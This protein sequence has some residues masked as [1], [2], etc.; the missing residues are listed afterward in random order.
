[1]PN[2]FHYLALGSN[3]RSQYYVPAMIDQWARV[4][5]RVYLGP[6]FSTDPVGVVIDAGWPEPNDIESKFVNACFAIS[7]P[8]QWVDEQWCKG[9]AKLLEAAL[10]R[11]LDL[12]N[13]RQVSRTIDVDYLFSDAADVAGY[14]RQQESYSCLGLEHLLQHTQP[15]LRPATLHQP[16]SDCARAQHISK[17]DFMM[18]SNIDFVW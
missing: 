5:G 4:F 7:A 17:H 12:P 10:G 2:R 6:L 11:P 3:I 8:E 1:M 15:H 14:L 16:Q 9:F 18:A 13:R